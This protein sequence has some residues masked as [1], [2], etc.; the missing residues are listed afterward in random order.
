MEDADRQPPFYL[1]T[2]RRDAGGIEYL[3]EEKAAE[4]VITNTNLIADQIERISP[5]SPDSVRRSLKI[6][7]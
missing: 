7:M 5:V 3:G 4:V 1:R 6:P 2:T